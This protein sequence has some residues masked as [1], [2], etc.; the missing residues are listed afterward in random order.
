VQEIFI[1][2]DG[3]ATKSII[4]VED[5]QGTLLGRIVAGPANIRLSID[6]A[7]ES[8]YTSLAAILQPL[9]LSLE[10]REVR[11]HAGIGVAGC[12]MKQ[13]Y[14]N[15]LERPHPFQTL[16]VTSDAY[17]ACLGAHN[18]NEGAIII[19]GTGTVGLQIQHNHTS[20]VGGW[21]FPLDDEGSGAWLGLEALRLTLRWR[22]GRSTHSALTEAIFSHFAQDIDAMVAWA[23]EANSTQFAALAPW[24]VTQAQAGDSAAI[25]LLKKAAHAIDQL[26]LAL[27]QKQA[28]KNPLPCVLLGGIA[29]FL[30]PYIGARLRER[31]TTCQFGADIGA[32]H[33]VKK[34][35]R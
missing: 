11:F 18:G 23:N 7:W 35:L 24:V 30:E 12:E 4:R 3:G 8:I 15:Y 9:S 33:L 5:Q 1:G 13:A 34:K 22:D 32:I 14:Q 10:S 2:V 17:T 6:Q 25:L 20:K 16:V 21:G 29:P 31:L 27:E 28:D 19:I 26:A